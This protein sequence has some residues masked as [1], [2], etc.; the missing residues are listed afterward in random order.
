GS[1][2]AGMRGRI[3]RA[4]AQGEEVSAAWTRLYAA[5]AEHLGSLKLAKSYG[6]ERRHA[7]AFERA[8]LEVNDIGLAHLRGFARY[9]QQLVFGSAAVLAAIADL[10]YAV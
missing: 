7:E 3:A 9:R 1:R 6:A 10:S 8:S 4:R 2:R 5:I